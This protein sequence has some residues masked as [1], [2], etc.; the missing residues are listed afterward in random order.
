[1]KHFD[2]K[3][4]TDKAI[5]EAKKNEADDTTVK[6][7]FDLLDTD[8]SKSITYEEYMKLESNVLKASLDPE[9]VQR[10]SKFKSAA[11]MVSRLGSGTALA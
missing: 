9:H 7:M 2:G 8:Q 10:M 6:M 4:Q 5:W 1:M 11:R 3:T